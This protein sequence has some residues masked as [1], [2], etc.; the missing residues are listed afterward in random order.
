MSSGTLISPDNTWVLWAILTGWAAISIWLEQNYN[1]AS[2]ITGAIIALIGAMVLAN[3]KVIPTSAPAYDQVWSYVVPLAI[4]LLLYKA[5]VRKIWRESGRILI[6]YLISSVGTMLGAFIGFFLLKNFV[7]SLYKVAAMMAGSY[8]GGGVNFVATADAFNAPGELVSAA[9]VADNLLMAL[10]FFVLIAIPSIGLFRKLY[11]HPHI[12]EVERKG[13]N[14]KGKTLAASYW[15]RKEISLK[16]IAFAAG[17]AFTIVAVS[18]E[19]A[20]F[21]GSIIPTGN[22]ITDLL[23]G[24]LGNKYLI[25]TTL[26]MLLATYFPQFFGNIRGAQELGTFLIYIFFVVIGVPASIPLIISKSP[27][28]LVFCTIMVLCN[29]LVTLTFGKLFNFDLEEMLLASNA[30]IGGPTTAAAMAIAK[31]WTKL[32]IPI[33]LVGTLGYV[34][35]NYFGIFMGNIL[36]VL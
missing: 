16:D 10:Y 9:V 18:G 4:P 1:W 34:I 14:D 29:M 21:L 17:S 3:L 13:K 6:I 5:N 15:G 32:V 25:M 19:I 35:G 20:S 28:L 36:Q 33:L 30:N 7:S 26:T 23:N 11:K 8:I 2:K 24:M 12:D 31:G 22:F 27:L